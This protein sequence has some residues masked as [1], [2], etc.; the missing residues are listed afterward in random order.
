MWCRNSLTAATSAPSA[1]TSRN[2]RRGSSV[3]STRPTLATFSA[4]MSRTVVLCSGIHTSTGRPAR[5]H[6]MKPDPPPHA[7]SPRPAAGATTPLPSQR[8]DLKGEPKLVRSTGHSMLAPPAGPGPT[9]PVGGDPRQP[10]RPHR[11]GGARRL[12]RRSRRTPGQ[13]GWRRRQARSNGP[14]SSRR[15]GDQPR[16]ATHIP[17]PTHPGGGNICAETISG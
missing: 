10:R 15:H 9:R 5:R 3:F 6:A 2:G 7:Q 17:S 16:H 4:V 1:S 8:V 14:T 13:P 11:R 12:A